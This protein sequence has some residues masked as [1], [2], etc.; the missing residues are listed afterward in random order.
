MA[1][2]LGMF[3]DAAVDLLPEIKE[4]KKNISLSAFKTELLDRLQPEILEEASFL[5]LLELAWDLCDKASVETVKYEL[6]KC[7]SAEMSKINSS[8]VLRQVVIAYALE[9][10]VARGQ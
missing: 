6:W 5:K 9:T 4:S 1:E 10:N 7:Y 3:L 8:V 2:Q